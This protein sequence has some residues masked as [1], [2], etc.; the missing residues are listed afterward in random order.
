MIRILEDQ[1]RPCRTVLLALVTVSLL[2]AAWPAVGEQEREAPTWYEVEV[3]IFQQEEQGG[4]HAERWPTRVDDPSYPIWQVPAGCQGEAN[5]V[6][7]RLGLETDPADAPVDTEQ[8]EADA[9]RFYC[10]PEARRRLSSHRQALQRSEAYQPLYHL[11]W[12]QPGQDRDKA[13]AVPIPYHW[14]P[15]RQ[16]LSEAAEPS[17]PQYR[18]PLYGLIRIYRDRYLHAVVDLRLHRR[19]IEEDPSPEALVRA[20]LHRLITQ[21]RMR[22]GELHYLDHPALGVLIVIHPAEEPPQD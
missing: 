12:L 3:L 2:F 6:A 17:P 10:L 20:P 15:P 8:L 1:A 5:D 14:H 19:A 18:P 11:A 4:R 22:S 16:G 9:P 7:E 13:V 21:R